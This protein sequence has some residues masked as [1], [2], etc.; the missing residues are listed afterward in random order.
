MPIQWLVH[1]KRSESNLGILCRASRRLV[2][3]VHDMSLHGQSLYV[4]A[5]LPTAAMLHGLKVACLQGATPSH[6]AFHCCTG[7]AERLYQEFSKH[8]PD[9]HQSH[10]CAPC[11]EGFYP[12]HSS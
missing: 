6:E 4:E 11:E 7:E 1:D 5:L 2:V 3:S 8:R 10:A 9:V 12:V